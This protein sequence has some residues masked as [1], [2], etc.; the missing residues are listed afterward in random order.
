L[1]NFTSIR[2]DRE[3]KIWKQ[4]YGHIRI[5]NKKM[6][7]DRINYIHNNPTKGDYKSVDIPYDYYFSSAR[8]YATEE[9]NFI[10]LKVINIR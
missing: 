5:V 3:N 8:A 10:F 9:S 2:K 7:I 6:L 4:S 1:N